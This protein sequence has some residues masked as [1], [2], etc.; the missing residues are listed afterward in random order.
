MLLELMT[1]FR[2]RR[3]LLLLISMLWHRQVILES[4]GDNLSSSAE[5]RIRTEPRWSFGPYLQQTECPL[6]NRGY[7]CLLLLISMLWH[8]L[9]FSNRNETSCPPLLN[10][11]FE[12]NPDGFW[13]RISHKKVGRYY[14]NEY[15]SIRLILMEH[16]IWRNK[17]ILSGIMV[18]SMVLIN[19]WYFFAMDNNSAFSRI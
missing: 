5:C 3:C 9:A 10:A 13:T 18:N 8:R 4:K 19:L 15:Q 11:G 16:S 7:T 14:V 6:T 17:G 12:P 1:E 2:I